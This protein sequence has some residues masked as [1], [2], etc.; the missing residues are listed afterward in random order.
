MKQQKS[1]LAAA[2]LLTLGL[3][4]LL[5]A[6]AQAQASADPWKFEATIYGWFPAIG[7]TTSFPA[8]GGSPSIDVSTQQVIDALKMA[9]MGTFADSNSLRISSAVRSRGPISA[10]SIR[11]VFAD[12]LRNEVPNRMGLSSNPSS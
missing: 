3:A 7:G 5:P 6:A 1:T 10:C 2:C 12:G 9:F 4:G 8:S 11:T